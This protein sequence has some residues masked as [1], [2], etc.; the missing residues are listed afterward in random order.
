MTARRRLR[1]CTW[2]ATWEPAESSRRLSLSALS[3]TDRSDVRRFALGI[4]T[5]RPRVCAAGQ[6]VRR[7]YE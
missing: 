1:K 3:S 7:L 5:G 6:P 4:A 2:S